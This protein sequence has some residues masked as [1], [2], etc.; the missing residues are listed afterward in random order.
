M[1]VRKLKPIEERDPYAAMVLDAF[2]RLEAGLPLA[3]E[4]RP[5]TTA[6][7][8]T[9]RREALELKHDSGS[10]DALMAQPEVVEIDTVASL[11]RR[12][13]QEQANLSYNRAEAEKEER[14]GNAYM[15]NFHRG[16]VRDRLE[17]IDELDRKLAAL[18]AA[19][20][21]APALSIAAE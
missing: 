1:P 21:A 11:T 7:E 16:R 18:T 14:A 3:S 2:D 19:Q 6:A 12:I 8:T 10:I 5:V 15:A 17:L 4:E 20:D 13:Q 9:R